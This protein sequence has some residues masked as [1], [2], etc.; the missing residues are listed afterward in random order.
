MFD[1]EAL[2]AVADLLGAIGV[3][4]TLGYLS[5]QIRQNTKAVKANSA[6]SVYSDLSERFDDTDLSLRIRAKDQSGERLSD[7]E[8]FYW[9]QQTAKTIRMYENQWF[10]SR[11]GAL[12]PD[13]FKGYQKHALLT[14]ALPRARTLYIRMRDNGY[15]H[16]GFVTYFD[17][18]IA[19]LPG[20][21]GR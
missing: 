1:W 5:V 15:F 17:Q 13:L 10:Q 16:P 6:Q 4:A 2:G 18:H 12:D 9:S 20:N 21:P 7:D 11:S 14:L 8:L 3:I 19:E